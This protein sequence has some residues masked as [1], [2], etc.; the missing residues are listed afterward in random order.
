MLPIFIIIIS[1]TLF[2]LAS[3]SEASIS[4]ISK[5]RIHALLEQGKSGAN[6]LDK[7]QRSSIGGSGTTYIVMLLTIILCVV[8]STILTI[9]HINQ[10]WQIISIGSITLLVG[11]ISTYSF[12]RLIA[13][14]KAETIA[15]RA[16]FL[17]HITTICLFPIIVLT[18]A[19]LDRKPRKLPNGTTSDRSIFQETITFPL[20]SNDEPLDERE[21]RMIRGVVQ[22]D[23]T[24]AR[25]IMV[26]RVDMIVTETGTDLDVV[27]ELML[28]S[29]HSRIPVYQDNLDSVVGIVY[30]RDLLR[31]IVKDGFSS[32]PLSSDLVRPPLFIPESKTLEELLNEFQQRHVHLAI[33]VDEYGGISGLVT[34]EDLLEEIVGEIQDEFDIGESEFEAISDR[35]FII[36]ARLS[37]DQV[38][39]LLN[40]SIA[41]NGFDTL[42][43]YVYHH[44]GK[45][46]D[47]GDAVKHGSFTI[48]VLSVIGRRMKRLRVTKPLI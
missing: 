44:L 11:L 33:V 45:I 36:D 31:H 1:F 30:A 40:I 48:E 4:S 24:I 21:A 25:E 28:K 43:G 37:I 46:P 12:A 22:L 35:E 15:L 19:I 27:V 2:F 41:G 9:N 42:G 18:A 34:I 38:N 26:P 10:S 8:Y 5:A 39:D 14:Y 16:S 13:S 7:L 6:Y 32:I 20:V 47:P 29:G 3:A 17:I 23:K